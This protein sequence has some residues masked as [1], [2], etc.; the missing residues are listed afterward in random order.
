[1]GPGYELLSSGG[2]G[3]AQ[4]SLPAPGQLAPFLTLLASESQLHLSKSWAWG[5][6]EP[7]RDGAPQGASPQ[8]PL[9]VLLGVQGAEG[10]RVSVILRAGREP[11][12]QPQL[13]HALGDGVVLNQELQRLARLANG[14]LHLQPGAV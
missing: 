3:S 2:A 8:C 5:S 7:G 12:I 11:C 1:M 4:S 14:I 10:V 9:Q 13:V 6:T